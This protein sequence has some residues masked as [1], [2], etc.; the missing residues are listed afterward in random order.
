L[1][2]LRCFS[3]VTGVDALIITPIS[4]A[5]A[6]QRAGR[7]GRVS[8]GK[9][10]RLYTEKDFEALDVSTAPEIQRQ[11]SAVKANVH[12]TNLPGLIL[13]LL[14]LGV[15]DIAHFDFLSSPSAR[16]VAFALEASAS[17]LF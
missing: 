11:R 4:Q 2:Q 1:G 16:S 13:Q 15:K 5:S 9:V 7:T 6:T 12:R 10:F 3:T 14:A 17:P 8:T